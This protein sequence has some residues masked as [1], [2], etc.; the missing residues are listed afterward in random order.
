MAKMIA[1]NPATIRNVKRSAMHKRNHNRVLPQRFLQKRMTVP[2]AIASSKVTEAAEA[3]AK[4]AYSHVESTNLAIGQ[5]ALEKLSLD[6]KQSIQDIKS[7][8]EANTNSLVQAIKE[9]KGEIAAQS[10]SQRLEWALDQSD[11]GFP[12]FGVGDSPNYTSNG[13]QF[14]QGLLYALRKGQSYSISGRRFAPASGE[15]KEEAEKRFRDIVVSE[16]HGLT[17]VEPQL[18]LCEDGDYRIHYC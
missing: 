13:P 17:G 16:I 4:A 11:M 12:D 6:S 3:L 8:M 1:Y 5:D 7:T 10:K 14:L 18:Q 15:T 9:L 2:P